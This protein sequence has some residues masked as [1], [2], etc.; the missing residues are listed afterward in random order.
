MDQKVK[1]ASEF[2][3]TVNEI[4]SSNSSDCSGSKDPMKA[5]NQWAAVKEKHTMICEFINWMEFT[6]DI[7]LD[8]DFV[9]ESNPAPIQIES[10][11]DKFFGV[12][13][14]QLERDRRQLLK[15]SRV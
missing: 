12:D 3:K 10:L 8:Y 11:V 13:R 5:L 15:D 7:R 6:F 14:Q 1:F 4:R 9:S 2:G